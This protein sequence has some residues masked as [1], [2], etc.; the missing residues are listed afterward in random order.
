MVLI[1]LNNRSHTP[2]QRVPMVLRHG[3]SSA[4]QDSCAVLTSILVIFHGSYLGCVEN[5]GEGVRSSRPGA[6]FWSKNARWPIRPPRVPE[7][8]KLLSQGG[9]NEAVHAMDE[10]GKTLVAGR[11]QHGSYSNEV[12]A[13]SAFTCTFTLHTALYLWSSRSGSARSELSVVRNTTHS[14]NSLSALLH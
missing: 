5:L 4:C 2:R 8:P 12:S 3:D 11:L 10:V 6:S 7:H 13:L 1:F 14:S 9:W